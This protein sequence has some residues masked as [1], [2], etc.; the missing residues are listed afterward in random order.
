[1]QANLLSRGIGINLYP[2]NH[3]R[4][5]KSLQKLSLKKSISNSITNDSSKLASS[6]DFKDI[7]G[8]EEAKRA[9]TIAAAGGHHI[10]L[11]GPPGSGKSM[12]AQA[13][14]GI[15]PPLTQEE[16]LEVTCLHSLVTTNPGIA[17]ERPFRQPHH[18]LSLVGLVGGTAKLIPGEITL[19]H[20]GILF[21]DE[22]AEFPRHHLEALRQPLSQGSITL[23]KASGNVSY[24]AQFCLVAA[25]NPCPCGFENRSSPVATTQTKICTCTPYDKKRYQQKISG[26]IRDRIDLHIFVE[27]V[28]F[29][30]L[31]SKNRDTTKTI[32]ANVLLA[33]DIQKKRQQHMVNA[34]IPQQL[35]QKKLQSNHQLSSTIEM[36]HTKL[37]LSMRATMSLMR[38]A[39]TIADLENTEMSPEHIIEAAQYRQL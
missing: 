8:Q 31:N 35:I 15:L 20:R 32:R 7:A 1:M 19:A 14:T 16:Q 38:V 6:I 39:Q 27:S 21:L 3:L 10:L 9:L 23:K 29:K 26:P 37:G 18:A 5:L 4:E 11:T 34:E 12:L 24:P 28:P 33:R 22:I 17:T 30:Q 25:T 36:I 13:L 2:L